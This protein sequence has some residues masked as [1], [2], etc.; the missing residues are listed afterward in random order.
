MPLTLTALRRSLQNMDAP[1][2]RGLIETLFQAS[3]ANKNLLTAL[4]DNDTSGLRAKAEA[5]IARAFHLGKRTPTLK[6]SGALAAIAAYA[7]VASPLEVLTLQLQFVQAGMECWNGFGGPDSLLD[8]LSSMWE[9]ALK[10][11]GELPSDMLPWAQLEA[12]NSL[13]TDFGIGGL[14]ALDEELD[15]DGGGS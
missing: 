7:K 9:S 15:E 13:L 10:R 8:S 12:V 3:T 4:L 1:E 5:E 11:A 14:E 2:L 6:T